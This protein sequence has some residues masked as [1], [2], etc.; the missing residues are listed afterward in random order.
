MTNRDNGECAVFDRL[1][2][3]YRGIKV[4][5]E[6]SFSIRKGEILGY[7]GPN[8]AGKTTT[9]KT[10]VGLISD[11]QGSLIIGG[12]EMPGK[13]DEVHKLVG[14]LPQSVAFQEWRTVEHALAT[15][16]ALSGMERGS[17]D[18]GIEKA[19]KTLGLSE[20]RHRKITELSG[21]NVQKVGLAQAILHDPAL[22]ILDEPLA[23]LD[24]A[25][26]YDV[27]QILRELSRKGTTIFFSSHILSDVQDVAHRI[28]ILN[29]GRLMKIGTLDELKSDFAVANSFA[30][31][32][33]PPVRDLAVLRELPGLVS[34]EMPSE[35][36]L[37]VRISPDTETDKVS[38]GILRVLL[39]SGQTIISFG[40]VSPNLDELYIRYVTGG[41]AQ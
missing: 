32:L 11:F 36:C 40:P 19:L 1:S 9:I 18:S 29:R 25:S 31:E 41:N 4:L 2:K 3:E 17:I 16:G 26:R 22:L 34:L 30:V 8:G 7:V 35:G 20:F 23:G 27:K 10:M 33:R 5:N 6:V 21:G 24:P 12:H 38:A 28:A 37:I 15:F 39:D 13:R 14:Y